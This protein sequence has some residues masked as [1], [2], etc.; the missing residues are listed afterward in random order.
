MSSMVDERGFNQGYQLN[1]AQRAR[2][3]WRARTIVS[4]YACLWSMAAI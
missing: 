3:Q 4:K 1:I 2:L